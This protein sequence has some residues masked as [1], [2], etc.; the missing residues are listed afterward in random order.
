MD[1]VVSF[2][3]ALFLLHGTV[4]SVGWK[5]ISVR[6]PPLHFLARQCVVVVVAFSCELLIFLETCCD[7]TGCES[8]SIYDW[9][10][11]AFRKHLLMYS[12]YPAR[13]VAAS[14]ELQVP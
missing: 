6:Q 5:L 9:P 13:V 8:L 10:R 4:D 12:Y 14:C 11:I 3:V 2:V 1:W 7:P